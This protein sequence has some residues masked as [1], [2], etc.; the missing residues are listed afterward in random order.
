LGQPVGSHGGRRHASIGGCLNSAFLYLNE[1]A[2][3]WERLRTRSSTHSVNNSRHPGGLDL[4]LEPRNSA[5][6]VSGL[7]TRPPA[8]VGGKLRFPLLA[9][10]RSTLFPKCDSY[11]AN[12]SPYSKSRDRRG[13]VQEPVPERPQGL[14]VKPSSAPAFRVQ[15][16]SFSSPQG[17]TR[18]PQCSR[19]AQQVRKTLRQGAPHVG[20]GPPQHPGHDQ[21]VPQ[22]AEEPMAWSRRGRLTGGCGLGAGR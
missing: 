1:T 8:G 18:S 14:A 2:P 17:G 4:S 3:R 10:N 21:P 16:S 13:F 22:I 9:C 5:V 12:Q 11:P 20:P 15:A 19:P 6:L 7:A